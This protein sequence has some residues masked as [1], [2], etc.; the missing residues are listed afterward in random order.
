MKCFNHLENDA[1]AVCNHC[2]KSICADCQVVANGENYCKTCVAE[3]LNKDKKQEHSPALAAILS[4][5]VPGLG[6]VYNG[7]IGKA[8]LIFLTGWLIIPWI[9]GIF[10][11][12]GVAKKICEGKI[13]SKTKLGCLI[14]SVIGVVILFM[15]IFMVTLLA[16][17]AIP[18]FLRA[19]MM[20]SESLA[21]ETVISI[22]QAVEAYRR[23]NNGSYPL[24]EL[25]LAAG[26]KGY[27][28]AGSQART[29][30]YIIKKTFNSSGY[31]ITASPVD[32]G[33][34]GSKVFVAATGQVFSSRD[35]Q[36]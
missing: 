29:K 13:I 15:G 30:G 31:T 27:L 2:G 18:N 22:S 32:C 24:D 5:I 26:N 11:A 34:S 8:A 36:K 23:D 25:S 14:A 28:T 17:I 33:T 6:Q 9:I 16:A 4:F 10:D 3:K 12:Y 7:Q 21:K 20:A 35:C 19:R 1:V